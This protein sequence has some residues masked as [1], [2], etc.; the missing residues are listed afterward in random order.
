MEQWTSKHRALYE[1]NE[2]TRHR[3]R[4]RRRHWSYGLYCLAGNCR[5]EQTSLAC[6]NVCIMSKYTHFVRLFTLPSTTLHASLHYA[7]RWVVQAIQDALFTS[8][9][10]FATIWSAIAGVRARASY[11]SH[12]CRRI[13]TDRRP[14]RLTTNETVPLPIHPEMPSAST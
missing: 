7:H 14:H 4:Y 2:R 9:Y 13:D 10:L 1:T 12:W 5:P 8:S 6:N 11:V 3:F